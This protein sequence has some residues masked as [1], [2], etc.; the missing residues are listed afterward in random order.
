MDEDG[1][2]R[3]MDGMRQQNYETVLVR[4]VRQMSGNEMDER[5]QTVRS[6]AT[7]HCTHQLVTQAHMDS[8]H[9]VHMCVECCMN[10]GTNNI[11]EPQT[12]HKHNDDNGGKHWSPWNGTGERAH[13]HTHIRYTRSSNT[14]KMNMNMYQPVVSVAHCGISSSGKNFFI[15]FYFSCWTSSLAARRREL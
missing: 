1:N 14:F 10:T 12:Q 13:S 9:T 4:A 5:P 8:E 3:R 2:E 15:P 6:N 7:V 11:Y